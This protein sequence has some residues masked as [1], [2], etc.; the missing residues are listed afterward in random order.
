MRINAEWHRNNRMPKNA[1]TEQRIAWHLEHRKHCDC[2][3]IPKKLLGEMR[4]G[5]SSTA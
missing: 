2:R 3:P 4:E 1:T 5:S